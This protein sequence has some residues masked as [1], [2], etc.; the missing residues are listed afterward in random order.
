MII[1]IGY[2]SCL[3]K[4]IIPLFA[5]QK[6]RWK[7][8]DWYLKDTS[9]KSREYILK[10]VWPLMLTNSIGLKVNICKLAMTKSCQK[11][12]IKVFGGWRAVKLEFTVCERG[13]SLFCGLWQIEVANFS[14]FSSINLIRLL[15]EYLLQQNLRKVEDVN[16]ENAAKLDCFSSSHE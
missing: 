15:G 10:K 3:V 5:W 13:D 12:I 11:S 2:F 8:Y 16:S 6:K 4:Q 9:E 1:R 14:Q 7:A